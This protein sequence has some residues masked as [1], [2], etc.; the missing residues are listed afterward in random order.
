MVRN[1]Y[2]AAVPWFPRKEIFHP[3]KNGSYKRA[4]FARVSSLAMAALLIQNPVYAQQNPIFPGQNPLAGIIASG[5]VHSGTIG[6]MGAANDRGPQF[7]ETLSTE[8]KIELLRKKVKYVFVL[9]QENRSFDHYFG[10]FPGANGLF[11]NHRLIDQP[12]SVQRIQN[13]DGTYSNI[14]PFLIPRTI[15]DVNGNTVQLYPEDTTSTDHSHGGYMNDFHFQG[16]DRQAVAANN[17]YALDEEGLHYSGTETTDDTIVNSSGAAPTTNPTLAQKQMGEMAMAHVDCDTVPFYWQYA[18]RF[19]LFDNFHQTTFGPSTPNAIAMIAGQTGETQWAL[20]P[21]EADPTGLT[22]PNETDVGPWTGSNKDMSPVKPPYGPDES[23]ANPNMNLTFATLPLSFMGH[24]VSQIAKYDQNPTVNQADVQQDMKTVGAYDPVVNWGWYQQGYDAEPYDGTTTPDGVAH[25]LHSSYIVHHN[26]FQYF[27]YLGDNTNVQ[28]HIHGQNDFY[29]DVAGKKLPAGG[30]V[31]YVRGGYYHMGDLMTAD[32]NPAVRTAFEGND[33]HGSYSDAQISEAS[34]ADSVNAIANS[35]YWS[36]SAIIISYD[37][38]D[39]QYDHT[40][41]ATRSFGPDGKPLSGGARFPTI[42]ISPYSAT[43][44]ISHVYSEHSSIIRFIDELYGL[45]PLADLPDEARG[46]ELGQSQAATLNQPDLGPADTSSEA[47]P[48]G[49]LTE[50][51]DDDRLMGTAPLVPASYA[52]IPT[53]EVHSLPHYDG[54]G[55]KVLHITPTDYKGNK[56]VDL[57]PADFNPRPS[58]TPGIPTSGDW[59]P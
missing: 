39:G 38:S 57:P 29:N 4:L 15:Q 48:M 50:A 54:D 59:A 5:L 25:T 11:K 44:T 24:D 55:C 20:H 18:D 12:G 27:G 51:F 42:V 49:D 28:Q 8:Q 47:F 6:T 34:V 37:E 56:P 10:T 41:P 3:M 46:R 33:E 2:E 13:V 53:A 21:S 35:P 30:G 19:T 22:L 36:Q 45:V 16:T 23:P 14:S 31:F 43:H 26:A 32:A 9:F 7:H 1:L 58:I 52:I 40:Q 17:G